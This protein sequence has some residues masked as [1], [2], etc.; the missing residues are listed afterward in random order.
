M[1]AVQ[2]DGSLQHI[3]VNGL[4]IVRNVEGFAGLFHRLTSTQELESAAADV[5]AE[6]SLDGTSVDGLTFQIRTIRQTALACDQASQPRGH[7][8]LARRPNR[9]SSSHCITSF[10]LIHIFYRKLSSSQVKISQFI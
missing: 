8:A 1:L 3:S 6:I 10:H 5:V 2:S 9:S 7:L 4:V